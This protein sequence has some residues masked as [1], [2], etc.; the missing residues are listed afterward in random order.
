MLRTVF[1]I[2]LGILAASVLFKFLVPIAFGL[3]GLAIKIVLVGAVAYGVIRLVAP[4]TARRL[5]D[6]VNAPKSY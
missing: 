6:R 2:G 3:L 1:A 5:H 4:D